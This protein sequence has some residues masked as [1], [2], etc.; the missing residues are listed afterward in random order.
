MARHTGKD[1]T[2]ISRMSW[3]KDTIGDV[4]L[5][6]LSAEQ[7][8]KAIEARFPEQPGTGNRHLQNLSAA[9]QDAVRE[10]LAPGQSLPAG[11]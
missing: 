2:R 8:R 3:W 10:G 7:I 4:S 11:P 5:N 9:L 6:R 1:P